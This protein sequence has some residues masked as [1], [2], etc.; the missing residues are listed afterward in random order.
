ME[1]YSDGELLYL[2]RCGN[3]D[4]KDT[5]LKRYNRH[6][7]FWVKHL[8]SSS[9]GLDFEDL[10]QIGMIRLWESLDSYRDD[11]K[12]SLHTFAKLVVMNR[13]NS[14]IRYAKNKTIFKDYNVVSL[15]DI[16]KDDEGLTYEEIVGDSKVDFQ[17]N[18]VA[19][20]KETTQEYVTDFEKK[21]TFIEKEVIYYKY[22]GY[23][24]KEILEILNIPIKS[25]YN[26]AY[27]SHKKS[28][29]TKENKYDKKHDWIWQK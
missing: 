9:F 21:A 14:T 15:D 6:I 24:E 25:V 16:V 10:V 20:I 28:A 27:R 13:V 8:E 3:D 5:L 17:P 11:Q 18:K 12:A 2:V 4:A 1:R 23:D 7:R 22:Q 29:L 26:A 19:L